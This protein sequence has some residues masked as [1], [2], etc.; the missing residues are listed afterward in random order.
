MSTL[1]IRKDN[2]FVILKVI[3]PYAQ[4]LKERPNVRMVS[5]T[6]WERTPLKWVVGKGNMLK[7]V[8]VGNLFSDVKGRNIEIQSPRQVKGDGWDCKINDD[9]SIVCDYTDGVYSMQ[10]VIKNNGVAKLTDKNAQTLKKWFVVPR[11]STVSNGTITLNGGSPA[12]RRTFFKS[13][14]LQDFLNEHCIT[15]VIEKNPNRTFLVR[16]GG[17]SPSFLR[18]DGKIESFTVP[19]QDNENSVQEKYFTVSNATWVIHSS[20]VKG[21][22]DCIRLLYTLENPLL[23]SNLLF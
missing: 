15:S 23:I 16:Y 20:Y 9:A 12:A 14:T 6:F 11:G 21:S 3:N 5:L 8:V 22:I 13:G 4:L 10:Y 18:T 17:D 7:I 1:R 19:W 2:C